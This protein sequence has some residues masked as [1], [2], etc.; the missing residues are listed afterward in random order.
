MTG[1]EGRAPGFASPIS[2]WPPWARRRTLRSSFRGFWFHPGCGFPLPRSKSLLHGHL[3]RI[4]GSLSRTCAVGLSLALI[5]P[6]PFS[7]AAN[8]GQQAGEKT[9]GNRGIGVVKINGTSAEKTG[10]CGTFLDYLGQREERRKKGC[11]LL[12]SLQPF[13]F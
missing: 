10:L 6:H 1:G 9:R 7:C 5:L 12:T 2:P 11:K 8:Y 3:W 4:R 13:D